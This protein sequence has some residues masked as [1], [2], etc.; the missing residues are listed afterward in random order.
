MKLTESRCRRVV[1]GT[2]IFS[3]V[4]HAIYFGLVVGGVVE[5]ARSSPSNNS[6][7]IITTLL[8]F[9]VGSLELCTIGSVWLPLASLIFNFIFTLGII[10]LL[11]ETPTVAPVAWLVIWMLV[12][13]AC[14][15]TS[16]WLCWDERSKFPCI[17]GSN[18]DSKE[19]DDSVA[20]SVA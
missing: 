19:G 4:L 10:Q 17:K 16:S 15:A 11:T 9:V 8:F 1:A 5:D 18:Q 6:G 3:A 2:L 14:F 13:F 20:I 7:V 12:D